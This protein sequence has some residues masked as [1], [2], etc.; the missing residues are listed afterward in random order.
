MA[1]NTETAQLLTVISLLPDGLSTGRIDYYPSD[2]NLG[3]FVISPILFDKLLSFIQ[4]EVGSMFSP[5]R[6]CIAHYHHTDSNNV[7][8]LEAYFRNMA[9]HAAVKTN[10]FKYNNA[11]EMLETDVKNINSLVECA[12]ET[13]RRKQLSIPPSFPV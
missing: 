13:S 1:E 9:Y 10:E 8:G 4:K 5:I 12:I 3:V 11:R 7:D 6:H 2:R